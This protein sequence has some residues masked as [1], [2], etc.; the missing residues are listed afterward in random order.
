M[1]NDHQW[2]PLG[3]V[4]PFAKEDKRTILL[5][6]ISKAGEVHWACTAWWSDQ[7]QRWWDGVEPAGFANPT[8]WMP[9]PIAISSVQQDES[10]KAK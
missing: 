6:S 3:T 4:P 8:H 5:A 2:M 10:S 1:S 9:L 7:Y